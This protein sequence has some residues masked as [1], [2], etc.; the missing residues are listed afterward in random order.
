LAVASGCGGGA[1]VANS[2]AA[3]TA[4]ETLTI[5][6]NGDWQG[7]DPQKR[8]AN[9]LS[10][11]LMV[12]TYDRLVAVD[13][14][15]KTV[16][17]Y[18]AKSWKAT[19][20]SVIFNLRNDVVCADGHKLTPSDVAASFAREIKSIDALRLFGSGPYQVAADDAA[21]T[22]T[23][24]VGTPYQ[25]L[26][27][28]FT[29]AFTGIVCPSGL[30][31]PETLLTTPSGSG[32]YLMKEAVHG[33]HATFTLRP[34]W[35]WGPMGTT[36]DT[37]GLPKTVVL[38]VVT[39]DTTSANLLTTGGL[40]VAQVFGP[41][42]TRM[43]NDKTISVL[44]THGYLEYPMTMNQNVGRPA[45]DI[46]VRKALTLAV[47]PKAYNQA[48]FA[49][50]G[51]VS[52]SIFT[53]DAHCYDPTMKSPTP[54]IN[55]ARDLLIKDGY[56]AGS[57]GRL[58]KNGIPLSLTILGQASQKS[59]PEYVADQF[60]KLGITV[61]LRSVDD[62]TF[63]VQYR[64]FDYD[65]TFPTS[66]NQVDA[67]GTFIIFL[68]GPPPPKGNNVGMYA[69]PKLDSLVV[70]AESAPVGDC[71]GW[72]AVQHYFQDNYLILPVGTPTVYWFGRNVSFLADFR[73]VQPWSLRGLKH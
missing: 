47:D 20:S 67:P 60:R 8:P 14:D 40:D 61:T 5:R 34:E 17:P 70:A 32:P 29:D 24:T 64:Q 42:I 65:V 50:Y 46:E 59:G 21:G 71:T 57:D 12:F 41:D 26:L 55:A 18:V 63:S 3:P 62:T 22:F 33:D 52:P 48:A 25:D 73:I 1:S 28:G 43:L 72:R 31:H 58:S 13:K 11:Q 2:G 36:A 49:G 15:H 23:M 69:D 30:A 10:T 16:I 44:P 38:R 35:K 53:P 51:T 45:A 4:T 68:W 9:G 6:E 56:V 37:V 27:Y 54:S 19:A 7:L 66:S 39:N